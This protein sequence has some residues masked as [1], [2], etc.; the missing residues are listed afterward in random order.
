MMEY[1]KPIVEYVDFASESVTDSTGGEGTTGS[2]SN[3][4]DNFG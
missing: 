2:T 4:I 3:I 1:E